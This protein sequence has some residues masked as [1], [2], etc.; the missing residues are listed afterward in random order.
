MF[1][2]VTT[3]HETR[4]GDEWAT[5]PKLV[6]LD[7]IRYISC[8]QAGRAVIHWGPQSFPMQTIEPFDT[9]TERI[10]N[11][12]GHTTTNPPASNQPNRQTER[13]P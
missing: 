8:D 7:H 10:G 6:N 3:I 4:H 9:I 5:V 12:G 2:L 1:I 13:E 11:S